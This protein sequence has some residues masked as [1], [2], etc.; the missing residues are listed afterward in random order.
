MDIRFD[1]R[2]VLVTGVVRGIGRALVRGFAEAG[3][4]VWAADIE[5]DL[6]DALPDEMPAELRP[7]IH[8]RRCDVTDPV[9]LA[10]LV[11]E[12]EA[13]STS[14][15]VDVAVHA[16][17][18]VCGRFRTP[19]E[20]V[21]DEDWRAIQAVN[22]DGAFNLARAVVPGMKSAGKGRIVV[23]S[24]RAGLG[25]SRTGVQSYGTAKAAQIGLVR[26]LAAELGPFG[27]TVNSVAP[28]FM[29]TSPDYVK[30]WEA[31]GPEV[32]ARHVESVAMRR[33]GRPEDIANATLFLASDQAE[34]ITGQTLAVTGGP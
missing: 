2:A 22:V 20:L 5:A 26:Q 34:W 11:D 3:A 4:T 21:T 16:A 18:G 29:P 31:E 25:V 19:I 24:S 17:G 8:P 28:G 10:S 1:G 13:A 15:A 7:R 23:I 33:L 6:L 14:D 27:I 9:A 32:Q 12:I 30:Q